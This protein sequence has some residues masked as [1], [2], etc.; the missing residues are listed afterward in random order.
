[1][2]IISEESYQDQAFVVFCPKQSHNN[3]VYFPPN[4]TQKFNNNRG[5]R[6]VHDD[7]GFCKFFHK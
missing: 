4:I 5:T 1:M 6:Q 7:S 2:N 3:H